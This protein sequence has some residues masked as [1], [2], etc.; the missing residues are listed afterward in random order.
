MEL[1]KEVQ[2]GNIEAQL[3]SDYHFH[4]DTDAREIA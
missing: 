1:L 4:I 2:I 3:R